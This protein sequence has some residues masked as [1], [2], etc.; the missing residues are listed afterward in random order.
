MSSGKQTVVMMHVGLKTRLDHRDVAAQVLAWV[1]WIAGPSPFGVVREKG[2]GGLLHG[3]DAMHAEP[4]GVDDHC[5]PTSTTVRH[6]D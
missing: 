5:A 4:P 6:H 1:M 2:D 3:D